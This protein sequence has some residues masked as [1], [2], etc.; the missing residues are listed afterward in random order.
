[1][2]TVQICTPRIS[3]DAALYGLKHAWPWVEEKRAMLA[4]RENAMRSVFKDGELGYELISAGG[5][6]AYI[7]HPFEQLSAK[8]VARSLADTQNI[9]CLPGS[10]FGP[11]QERF[12]RFAFANI[13]ERD[14]GMLAARLKES[15]S[16]LS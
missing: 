14:M 15:S 1:M 4:G 3:Q 6:F 5:Y 2:D 7:R 13:E 11:G 12:L 8:Q 9:L 10:F 16:T